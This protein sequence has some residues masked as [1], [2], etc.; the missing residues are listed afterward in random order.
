V[1]VNRDT[2]SLML[3]GIYNFGFPFCQPS[4]DECLIGFTVL[5]H[6]VEQFI[7]LLNTLRALSLWIN[8][9]LFFFIDNLGW[10]VPQHVLS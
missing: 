8:V 1:L 6:S 3:G 2:F 10:K 9:F 5:L 7:E 4:L